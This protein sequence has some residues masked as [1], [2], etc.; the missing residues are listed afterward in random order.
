M[1][2]VLAFTCSSHRPYYLRNAILQ[3]M[4]QSYSCDY[5]V[6]LN[7]ENFSS[8]DDKENYISL[9]RDL[10]N[11]RLFLSYGEKFHQHFNH[12]EAVKKFNIEDYDLFLKIDDDDIYRR[13]YVKH[14]VSDFEKNKWNFS[15]SCSYYLVNESNI[16]YSIIGFERKES[17]KIDSDLAYTMPGTYAFSRE[18]FMF[19]LEYGK[20]Y[21]WEGPYEDFSWLTWML[22]RYPD[23]CV[24]RESSDYT[25]NIHNKNFS[26]TKLKVM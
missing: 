8:Q 9:Y 7:S 14:I 15:A 1:T 5:S 6:Y 16:D 26:K 17:E 25:Y 22:N 18:A 12:M 11:D 13:H 19:I 10:I 2:R 21:N 23:K 3:M 20:T 4:A 24:V